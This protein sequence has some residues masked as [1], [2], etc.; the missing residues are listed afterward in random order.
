LL[1]SV[2]LNA[3][4]ASVVAP[5]QR[6]PAL[7]AVFC[8]EAALAVLSPGHD[9]YAVINKALLRGAVLDLQVGS[10]RGWVRPCNGLGDTG[11][12][13]RH[14]NVFMIDKKPGPQAPGVVC[15]LAGKSCWMPR[16]SPR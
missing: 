9:M 11:W 10:S 2:L 12:V 4:R 14:Q 16:E 15:G 3:L 7:H 6:L 5:F 13:S 1:C 8:A